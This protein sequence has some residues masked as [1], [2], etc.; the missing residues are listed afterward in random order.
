MKHTRIAAA[1]LLAGAAGPF[2]AAPA[3]AEPVTIDFAYPYS[4]LFDVTYEKILPAFEAAHPRTS[5]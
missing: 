4:H 5:R 2:V 1:A 3:A